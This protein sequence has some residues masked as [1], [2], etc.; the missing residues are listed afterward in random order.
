MCFR[1]SF[2]ALV[3]LGSSSTLLKAQATTE[4]TPNTIA[5]VT[6]RFDCAGG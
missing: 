3:L 6:T 4:S 5:G 2:V 1:R